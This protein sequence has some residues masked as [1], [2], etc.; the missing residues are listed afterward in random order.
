MWRFALRLQDAALCDRSRL[1]QSNVVEDFDFTS[2]VGAFATGEVV[3]AVWESH[4]PTPKEAL[5]FI[6]T[7]CKSVPTRLWLGDREIPAADN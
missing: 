6:D 4:T 2:A 7:R 3:F 1:Q 5:D